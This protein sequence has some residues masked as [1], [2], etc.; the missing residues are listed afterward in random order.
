[1]KSWRNFSDKKDL[2]ETKTHSV[3][4]GG[5]YKSL[6]INTQSKKKFTD[7]HLPSTPPEISTTVTYRSVQ[8]ITKNQPKT[9][10]TREKERPEKPEEHLFWDTEEILFPVK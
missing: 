4:A 8:I 10:S 9:T 6:V 7:I 3:L 2:G 1:M 5:K